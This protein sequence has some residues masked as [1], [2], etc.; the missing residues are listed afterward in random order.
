MMIKTLTTLVLAIILF[1][2][3]I[4]LTSAQ[5]LSG[6]VSVEVRLAPSQIEAEEGTY[7]IGY[8][9]LVNRAGVPVKPLQDVTIRLSS[10]YSDIASVPEFVTIKTNDVYTTFDVKVGDAEGTTTIFANY[11]GQTVFQELL[12]GEIKIDLPDN[13]ELVIHLPSALMH[14]DSEMPF[15][16]FLQN[17]EG[18]VIQAPYDIPIILDYED[19]LVSLNENQWI[20]KKGAYYAWG[21]V[22]TGDLVGTAFIRASQDELNIHTAEGIKISSSLPTGLKVN[23]FP[24]IVAK[25]LDRNLDIVV[26]LIDSQGLPALAQ[27]DVYLEFF[28]DNTYVGEQIDE[29]IKEAR[30]NGIIKKGD[31]SYHFREE[32]NLNN[33][34]NE[35]TIGASAKGLGIAFDCFLMRDAYTTENPVAVKKTMHVFALDQIPSNSQTV[36][37]YQIGTLIG[38]PDDDELDELDDEPCIDLE[39]FDIDQN[40]NSNIVE[41]H[42]ILS[43]ENL[44]SEGSFQ[45][46]NL[47]S[48]NSLLLNIEQVGNVES[49]TSYGTAKIQSG[50]ET[51]TASLS[52]TIK[53]IG[54]ATSP[55][56]I[57][58]TL[59]HHVTMIFSPIGSNTILFD[60]NGKFDLF[61]ISLDGNN[62]P[63]FVENKAKYLLLP[64]NELVEIEKE[65]T[66]AHANFPS[67]S[68]ATNDV[69]PVT[70]EAIPVGVSAD[71]SL[72][73]ETSYNRN[74]S[75]QVQIIL[76]YDEIDADSNSPYIGI[77]QLVDLRGNP[78]IVSN[79]LKVKLEST[80]PDGADPFVQ[81]PRFVTIKNGSS[82]VEFDITPLGPMGD[83]G[84]AANSNGVIGSEVTF[85][86]RSFLTKLSISAGSVDEPLVPGESVELKVYVDDQYLESV[87]GA[88]LKIV[89]DKNETVTPTK[90]QTEADG[91]A[92]IHFIP[93]RESEI[94]SFEIFATAEGYVDDKK[95]FRYTVATDGSG[96]G[97]FALGVPDW[98]IY[99]GIAIVVVIVA[100]MVVFLKKPKRADDEEDELE[101]FEDDEI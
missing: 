33:Q 55:T 84:I 1:T 18:V 11:G 62:R 17:T 22:S 37:V 67:E 85:T 32:L 8:V 59:K 4:P 46:I 65:R 80:L 74:P 19:S 79:E 87:P 7:S 25:E 41:F 81:T 77:V 30:T 101:L 27:E 54:S 35:I 98:L 50:Q 66:F 71:E 44:S 70:M 63:T 39:R 47:I 2:S 58:N 9:N 15:S 76:P 56:N 14:V 42:P 60:K 82:F 12:V 5:I 100:I 93:S 28:A 49:G 29:T 20:I 34:G 95:T 92:K 88:A 78:I 91:S 69:D 68:F 97:G 86:T 40:D 94:F 61:V 51:G 72:K 23:V 64:I 10:A 53:G 83:S 75:S 89:A 73:A 3:F 24:Q 21:V 43:N 26:S 38:L 16:V 96:N 52:S 31:F 57:V 36:G 6:N 48:S 99:V 13:L 90:I 45:K